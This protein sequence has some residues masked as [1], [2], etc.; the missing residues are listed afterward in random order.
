MNPEV[1]YKY[2][3]RWDKVAD[4]PGTRKC[5]QEGDSNGEY[6]RNIKARFLGSNLVSYRPV[7]P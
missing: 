3:K 6:Q 4:N 7:H 1:A 2:A 5:K